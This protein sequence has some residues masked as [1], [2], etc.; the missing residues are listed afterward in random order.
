MD[1]HSDYI[2]C[3]N[4]EKFK[5]PSQAVAPRAVSLI[6]SG[7]D[8]RTGERADGRKRFWNQLNNSTTVTDKPHMSMG[9]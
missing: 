7:L 8:E 3:M 5:V 1:S 4:F 6:V 9:S 2:L